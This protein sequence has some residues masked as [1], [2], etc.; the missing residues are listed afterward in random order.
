MKQI[1][2]YTKRS[3]SIAIILIITT[4][5][6]SAQKNIDAVFDLKWK[7]QIGKTNFRS[8]IIFHNNYIIATSV[9]NASNSL[10]DSQDG[11][12]I[13]EPKTG[14][15][16]N[17]INPEKI[18]DSDVNGV[19]AYKDKIYFGNDNGNFYCYNLNGQ[20]QWK[21]NV[22][23][24]KDVES[25]PAL[26]NVNGEE[27]A[28]VAFNVEG[29]GL[30]VLNSTT[31]QKVWEYIYLY[32][33]GS[34]MNA[35]AVFDVNQDGSD[36]VIFGGKKEA[37]VYDNYG[38]Y[39]LVLDGKNGELIWE[40]IINS[41]IQA[42]PLVLKFKKHTE[43]L[44][45][46][47]YS[48]L[49]FFDLKGNRLRAIN[50]D[51][52]D[53]GISGLFSTPA[54]SRDGSIMVGTSWWG[55]NDG[56]WFLPQITKKFNKNTTHLKG[57]A[58]EYTVTANVSASPVIAD[59]L[60]TPKP[61]FCICSENGKMYIF[62]QNGELLEKLNLRAGVEET[63]FVKNIDKDKYNEILVACLDGFLYCYK[64]KSKRK[65]IE[66]GQFRGDNRNSGV[67]NLK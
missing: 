67:V 33:D 4:L 24:G 58:Q 59:V 2:F 36:D 31:G 64:S 7:T 10:K 1:T 8:N 23:F 12:Y 3:I 32:D 62:S 9:G 25:T 44:I 65:K 43:I 14:K 16:V 29:H 63:M 27:A 55:Q 52:P 39:V 21:F 22:G 28:Y 5:S 60:G 38:N 46:E 40:N 56:I 53:I 30:I 50:L 57:T 47:A 49:N 41:G 11:I 19:A 45:T 42:S 35:P 51:N 37:N 17:H 20:E 26:L 61:Q 34:Y 54:V 48:N 18:G 66:W 6:V 13:I 15:I